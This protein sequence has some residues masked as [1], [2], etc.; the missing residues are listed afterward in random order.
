MLTLGL[1]RERKSCLVFWGSIKEWPLL[2]T[3]IAQRSQA[4]KGSGPALTTRSWLWLGA[5]P[6]R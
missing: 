2:P 4:G 1:E 3:S 6:S 5:G